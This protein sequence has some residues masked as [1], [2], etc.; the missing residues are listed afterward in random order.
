[1]IDYV[2]K[3]KVISQFRLLSI[4]TLALALN[5]KD[6][7]GYVLVKHRSDCWSLFL[8]LYKDIGSLYHL[9]SI[10][11]VIRTVKASLALP[12]RFDLV[13]VNE[14][15]TDEWD[16]LRTIF[17]NSS[18]IHTNSIKSIHKIVR[19]KAISWNAGWI[20]EYKQNCVRKPVIRYS[21][22]YISSCYAIPKI[23]KCPP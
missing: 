5:V 12:G 6:N 1:L 22:A 8:H 9:T 16:K 23:V 2:V 21:G 4:E 3:N 14:L 19:K 18:L 15:E 7:A 17:S 13:V 10:K 20:T 11:Q